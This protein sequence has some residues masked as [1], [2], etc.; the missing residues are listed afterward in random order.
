MRRIWGRSLNRNSHSISPSCHV[1]VNRAPGRM[2]PL[3]NKY[4]IYFILYHH[5]IKLCFQFCLRQSICRV[6]ANVKT[7]GTWEDDRYDRQ[8]WNTQQHHDH[9]QGGPLLPAGGE[10][11]YLHNGGINTSHTDWGTIWPITPTRRLLNF[12]HRS[13]SSVWNVVT[14]RLPGHGGVEVLKTWGFTDWQALIFVRL[15]QTVSYLQRESQRP[16]VNRLVSP[17]ITCHLLYDC[18]SRC[19]IFGRPRP[20]V[21]VTMGMGGACARQARGLQ[22]GKASRKHVD[23]LAFYWLLCKTFFLFMP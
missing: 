13:G 22:G 21:L 3:R 16:S 19:L 23:C 11:D 8:D 2:W 18:M 5:Q 12:S 7:P 6:L 20:L 14:L 4:V 10:C 15:N 9:G 17:P 1:L